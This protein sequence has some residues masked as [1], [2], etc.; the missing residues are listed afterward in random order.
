MDAFMHIANNIDWCPLHSCVSN[1]FI[2][3]SVVSYQFFWTM[4]F[5]PSLLAMPADVCCV[6]SPFNYIGWQPLSQSLP[7]VIRRFLVPNPHHIMVLSFLGL[8]FFRRRCPVAPSSATLAR[9]WALRTRGALCGTAQSCASHMMCAGPVPRGWDRLNVMMRIEHR[10]VYFM[11]QLRGMLSCIER[12]PHLWHVLMS[13]GN[14]MWI[15]SK[16]MGTNN[17]LVVFVRKTPNFV[18]CCYGYM[19]L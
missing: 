14:A 12:K 15:P 6:L 19:I 4:Y 13:R 2:C 7:F 8:T 5:D 17:K 9:V 10:Y 3:W 16:S 11:A 18:I 1:S